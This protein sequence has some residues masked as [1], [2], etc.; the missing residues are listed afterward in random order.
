M[1][2]PKNE[3]DLILLQ[4]GEGRTY[5]CGTMTAVF[6]TDENETANEYKNGGLTLTL[7]DLVL[8]NTKTMTKYFTA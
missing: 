1:K 6:K 8:T 4:A 3:T 7:A 5:E 2:H